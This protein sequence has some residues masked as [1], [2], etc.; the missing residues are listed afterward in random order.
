MWN[1]PGESE[2]DPVPTMGDFNR[3]RRFFTVSEVLA[4]ADKS[5]ENYY[6][7]KDNAEDEFEDYVLSDEA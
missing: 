1:S 6:N 4:F 7:L 3:E 2:D 5:L